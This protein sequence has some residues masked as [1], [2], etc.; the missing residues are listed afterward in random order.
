MI[1]EEQ[2]FSIITECEKYEQDNVSTFLWAESGMNALLNAK[3]T[4]LAQLLLHIREFPERLLFFPQEL[5]L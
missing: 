5:A 4:E 3:W 2:F 1:S